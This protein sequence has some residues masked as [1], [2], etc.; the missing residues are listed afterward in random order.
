MMLL[1]TCVLAL[2]VIGLGL[3]WA[4]QALA[5][6]IAE[7]KGR[8][9]TL[10]GETQRRTDELSRERHS[11][12]TL[13]T[14]WSERINVIQETLSR[15]DRQALQTV[16]DMA[17]A[18][19]PIVSV[20]RS[21]QVAGI[22]FGE[23]E[24]ELLLRTH[25]GEGLYLRK[26]RGLALGQEV[27]D[28][29]I[30][31]PG[32]VVPVDAKFPSASYRA[33]VEAADGESAK[34]AWRVFRDE[35]LTQLAA[36]AKYIQPEAGTSDYALLFVPSDIMY[37]QAFL[38]SRLYDQDNPI[39]RR[40]QELQVFGCSTQTL[41]PYLGLIRLGLRNVNIAEDVKGIRRQIAQLETVFKTF[42]G[43][44]D[45][46]RGHADRLFRHVEKLAGTRG[47]VFRLGEAITRLAAPPQREALEEVAVTS[48]VVTS[49]SVSREP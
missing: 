49:G 29:A 36:T 40:A 24:L 18:L 38:T 12:Q 7:L 10:L 17:A 14:S 11:Y 39:P 32:C 46:L 4:R 9:E 8:Y 27:V 41:M 15:L 22:E 21:P 23:A 6:W 44:W 43:D 20:F 48:E 3:W 16:A 45:I 5:L 1:V 30:S 42:D 13:V 34:A 33:W 26:P 28:F 35:V 47:S 25:L 31:L 19:K 2:V 37:Q